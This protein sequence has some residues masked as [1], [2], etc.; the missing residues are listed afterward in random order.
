MIMSSLKVNSFL[1]HVVG[2][3]D[4]FSFAT[5]DPKGLFAAKP[6]VHVHWLKN[7]IHLEVRKI[8]SALL[9]LLLTKDLIFM[10]E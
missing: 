8:F 9:S 6:F 5:L 7:N 3:L 10:I 4:L 1:V 2:N